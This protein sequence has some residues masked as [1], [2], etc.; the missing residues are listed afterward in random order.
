MQ[1][2]KVEHLYRLMQ[3]TS[4]EPDYS[5]QRKEIQVIAESLHNAKNPERPEDILIG[6]WHRDEE[7]HGG[8]EKAD[9]RREVLGRG[10]LLYRGTIPEAETKKYFGEIKSSIAVEAWKQDK[11]VIFIALHTTEE[12]GYVGND[13]HYGTDT[14]WKVIGLRAVDV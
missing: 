12:S 14:T 2:V 5:E 6:G 13:N 9:G 3:D 1:S 11:K 4:R 7:F 8:Y 10:V